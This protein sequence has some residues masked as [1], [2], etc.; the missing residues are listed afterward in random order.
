MQVKSTDA[1]SAIRSVASKDFDFHHGAPLQQSYCV[2]SSYR[3]G[4]SYLCWRL[5]QTGLLGAPME[6]LNPMGVMRVLTNRLKTSSRGDYIAKLLARRTSRNGVFGMKAHFHHFEAFLKE[7]PGLLEVLSPITFIY[8]SRQDRIAQAVS[9]ARALQTG[10]WTSRME[11]GPGARLQYDYATIANCLNDIARQDLDWRGWFRAR[12]I[13]PY[14]VTYD[15]LTADAEG[16]VRDIVGLLGVQNDESATVDIPRV[17]KQGDETNEEWI[18][19]FGRESKERGGS[20]QPD[21]GGLE[22]RRLA[23]DAGSELSTAGS[24]HFFERQDPLI[25]SLSGKTRTATGFIDAIRLRHRY[26]AIIAQNRALLQDARV[27]DLACSKGFWSLAALDSG[28]VHVAGVERTRK[29]V[30]AGAKTFADSGIKPESY[31][32]IRSGIFPALEAFEPGA[33][34]VILCKGFFEQSDFILFF[35]QLS[36]LRP[37][38][39][40]LDTKIINGLGPLARF[41]I[42]SKARSRRA[43]KA[44]KGEIVSIPNHELIEFLCESEFQWRLVDWQAMGI[45]DWT[46]VQDYARDTRRT[47]VLDRLS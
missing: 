15:D 25:K 21:D 19:R 22:D 40:I 17:D 11:A 12:G 28:A 33:F 16:V 5:W 18:E 29:L 24:G 36:R 35:E 10:Q 1:D 4:S 3:C 41:A 42:T 38:H 13:T 31:Q 46:G 8:I 20:H 45:V 27:L 39:V 47:Y 34:D 14:Q 2:A 30:E 7:Y 9:M 43:R 26:D 37:K 6:V 32:F 44:P 23:A